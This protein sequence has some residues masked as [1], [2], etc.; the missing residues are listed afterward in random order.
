MRRMGRRKGRRGEGKGGKRRGGGGTGRGRK[1][2]GV[3]E[4]KFQPIN[5]SL[6]DRQ[7]VRRCDGFQIL[8][9]RHAG[10]VVGWSPLKGPGRSQ[11]ERK[12]RRCELVWLSPVTGGLNGWFVGGYEPLSVGNRGG[13]W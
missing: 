7:H 6:K 9:C 3:H 8:G 5:G 11:S 10:R 1:R 4:T 2:G 12:R 13:I